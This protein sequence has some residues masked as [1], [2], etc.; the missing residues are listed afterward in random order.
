MGTSKLPGR[1][2]AFL[3]AGLEPL[4]DLEEFWALA[5]G[6][7]GKDGICGTSHCI[8][9]SLPPTAMAR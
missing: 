7:V 9:Q 2:S 8:R 5:P 4:S 3:H 6:L 1:D